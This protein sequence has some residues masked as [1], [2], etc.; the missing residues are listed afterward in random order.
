MDAS[1]LSGALSK[2]A[3]PALLL[4]AL[5]IASH[6]FAP[7]PSWQAISHALP[8][9][10]M[11][12]GALLAIR[13]RRTR[14]VW[15]MGVMAAALWILRRAA[16]DPALDVLRQ[17]ASIW[18]PFALSLLALT[19]ERGALTAEGLARSGALLAPLALLAWIA[20]PG[21]SHQA[22][23]LT[24]PFLPSPLSGFGALGHA[25][26]LA[27]IVAALAVA[28]A[29]IR[30][31]GPLT[32]GFLGALVAAG[33]ATSASSMSLS[34]LWMSGAALAL[35]VALVQESYRMAFLDELTRLPG[36]RAL[37]EAMMRLGR[38]YTLAMLDVDHFKQFNDKYGHDVG[39]R[40]LELVAL[41][42]SRVSGGGRAF[43]YGGE[44]FTILFEG[45]EVEEVK[46]HLEAVRVAV[47][48]ASLFIPTRPRA[49]QKPTGRGRKVSVTI[50]IGAAARNDKR[51]SPD[52][53]LT[54]ADKALYQA[55][56]KGRNQTFCSK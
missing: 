20:R 4:G 2:V 12:A 56:R 16:G 35:V 55:K 21:F 15:A 48:G 29:L 50:S 49:G 5:L 14:V 18:L 30:R 22:A 31:Q 46:E 36:R 52:E 11:G 43:R 23:F 42:L 40:V 17:G 27:W 26:T 53:V 24:T 41:Q 45:K 19:R 32:G 33:V 8:V 51:R 28:S 7:P 38:R 34:H 3:L 9:A 6:L 47:E 39:D 44:E 25:A 1:I 10:L 54:A 37:N 13:F